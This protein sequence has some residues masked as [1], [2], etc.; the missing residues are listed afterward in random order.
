M[1]RKT[2]LLFLGVLAGVLATL[3]ITQPRALLVGSAARA[4][5]SV[6]SRELNLVV[7]VFARVPA[8]YVEQPDDSMLGKW[9]S[10]GVLAGL[11]LKS[12]YMDL[13]IFCDWRVQPR[14]ESGGFGL[15]PWRGAG[16]GK[17]A[18]PIDASPAAKA[19]V[20]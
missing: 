6:T 13:K 20:M 9:A 4:A 17:V 14:G 7:A 15:G 2:S 10:T 1:M 16:R 12:T 3:M 5:V 8:S 11:D 19:G 18:A